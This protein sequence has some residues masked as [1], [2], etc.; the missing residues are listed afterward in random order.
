M[1][2]SRT[3]NN[4]RR[5]FCMIFDHI[6]PQIKQQ[7]KLLKWLIWQKM[8]YVYTFWQGFSRLFN[9]VI[10]RETSVVHPLISKTSPN[11]RIFKRGK[12][13]NSKNVLN[14]CHPSIAVWRYVSVSYFYTFYSCGPTIDTRR[15]YDYALISLSRKKSW[16]IRKRT[17]LLKI[18]FFTVH[19]YY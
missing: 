14:I 6:D 3:L 19:R 12:K 17:K 15:V 5:R 4:S 7:Y 8:I 10:R 11:H 9:M 13:E 1:S 18:I 16:S 2:C